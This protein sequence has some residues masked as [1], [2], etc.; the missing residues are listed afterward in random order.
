MNGHVL[1]NWYAHK[2]GRVKKSAESNLKSHM[3]TQATR[4]NC[5]CVS[6]N[7]ERAS[8]F[9]NQKLKP[10]KRY[11][12]TIMW[13]R[14]TNPRIIQTLRGH[15]PLPLCI[16]TV[17]RH[18]LSPGPPHLLGLCQAPPERIK[19]RHGP[20]THPAHQCGCQRVECKPASELQ[21]TANKP[22]PNH[23]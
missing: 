10:D 16:P 22:I 19:L 12:K 17:D 3:E 7:H 18:T 9:P 11:H 2:C 14:R 5:M 13:T 23:H 20:M 6:N 8:N 4:M 1:T 21:D 15:L